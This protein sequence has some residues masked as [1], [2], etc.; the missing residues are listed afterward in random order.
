M[1]E[2][3]HEKLKNEDA[4]H[5]VT[6]NIFQR[7]RVFEND[8]LCKILWNEIFFYAELYVIELY[9]FVI[10]PDH[11]HILF[12]PR[13]NKTASEFIRGIKSMSAKKILANPNLQ[14]GQQ[15]GWGPQTPLP[16][17]ILWQSSY[18]DY[19]TVAKNVILQKLE[20]IK[21]NPVKEN[22]FQPYVWLYLNPLYRK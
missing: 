5:F 10:M 22:L 21:Q 14:P 8:A 4:C 2:R 11:L 1:M 6:T 7:K 3:S 9:G 13:G 15:Y 17:S 19:I 20:Y 12:W 16:H 18:F